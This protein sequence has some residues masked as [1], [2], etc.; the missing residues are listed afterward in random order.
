MAYTPSPFGYSLSPF[1]ATDLTIETADI[2]DTR[3]TQL[4]NYLQTETA[5]IKTETDSLASAIAG[6]L[7]PSSFRFDSFVGVLPAI[8]SSVFVSFS[9]AFPSGTT[10]IWVVITN[11]HYTASA[12]VLAADPPTR[13]GFDV[14]RVSGGTTGGNFRVN[15][16]AF[17]I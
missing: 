5:S 14:Y 6:K 1:D 15:Y 8:G 9:S 10:N 4:A 13:F 3:D 16:I 2:L 12:A 11:G 17:T 7:D